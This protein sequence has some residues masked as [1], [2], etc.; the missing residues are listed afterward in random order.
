MKIVGAT[1]L[2]GLWALEWARHIRVTN[3]HCVQGYGINSLFSIFDNFRDI[4]VHMY[5]FLKIMGGL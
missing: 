2:S 3:L 1:C 4:C 5:D